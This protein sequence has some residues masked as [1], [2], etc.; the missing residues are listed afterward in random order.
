M[1]VIGYFIGL[2]CDI[3]EKL[4]ILSCILGTPSQSNYGL[5]GNLCGLAPISEKKRPSRSANYRLVFLVPLELDTA[6]S[7]CIVRM[8]GQAG[9]RRLAIRGGLASGSCR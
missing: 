2:I 3:L 8:M 6:D 9:C 5:P 7:F 4:Q 1:F